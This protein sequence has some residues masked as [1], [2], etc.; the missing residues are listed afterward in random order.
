MN[1]IILLTFLLILSIGVNV[2]YN[3]TTSIYQLPNCFGEVAIHLVNL[4]KLSNTEFINLEKCSKLNDL[5]WVCKCEDISGSINANINYENDLNLNFFIQYYLNDTSNDS[6]RI[7][8][9]NVIYKGRVPTPPENEINVGDFMLFIALALLIIVIVVGAIAFVVYYKTNSVAKDVL[10]RD[11]IK[12]V[13]LK[14]TSKTQYTKTTTR[15]E[16]FIKDEYK[17]ELNSILE[18][19]NK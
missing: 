13:E 3:S 2:D 10:K 17:D 19:I 8:T 14:P 7:Q 11:S 12:R 1:K 5:D 15:P 9:V 6:R 16:T 18:D 4:D